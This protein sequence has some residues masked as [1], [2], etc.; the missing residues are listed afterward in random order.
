MDVHYFSEVNF[1]R[2]M[3]RLSQEAPLY[4]PKEIT[5]NLFYQRFI[6]EE[7]VVLGEARTMEPLKAFFFS[8]NQ[9]VA[10]YPSPSRIKKDEGLRIFLGVKACDLQSLEILDEVFIDGE[11]KEPFYLKERRN[12]ILI[13]SDCTKP[14]DACFCNLVDLEPYPRKGFDL[15]LSS[16]K[17]GFLV[18]VGS[19]KGNEL[20]LRYKEFFDRPSGEQIEEQKKNR[21][22]SLNLLKVTNTSF[23]TK[24]SYQKIVKKNYDSPL[25]EEET[26]DCVECGLCTNICPTCHCYLLYDEK[27]KRVFNRMRM[28]DSCQYRGF[29]RV[30]GGANPR[31]RLAERLRHRYLHKLD[32]FKETTGL[33]MCTGCG[34]CVEGCLGKIDMREVLK[35]LDDYVITS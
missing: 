10:T 2:W 7:E 34:R 33:Y 3:E 12:T 27:E 32:Y 28:W 30:A 21:N 9:R 31:P 26:E 22:K 6:P 20:L 15:N 25:W 19:E 14:R 29:A 24:K 16:L 4:H 18:E 17:E 5:G 13:S 11:Y 8:L 35:K 23:K 1:K